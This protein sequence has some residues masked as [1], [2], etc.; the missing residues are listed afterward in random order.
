MSPPQVSPLIPSKMIL[1]IDE[2]STM[3]E[4]FGE[5]HNIPTGQLYQRC[6]LYLASVCYPYRGSSLIPLKIILS[7][8]E[9][10]TIEEDL[11]EAHQQQNKYS[12]NFKK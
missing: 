12:S 2:P 10:S 7:I 6:P 3:K 4:A 11:S 9:P 1:S 8:D 5:T